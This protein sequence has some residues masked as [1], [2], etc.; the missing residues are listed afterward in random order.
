[1]HFSSLLRW[2]SQPAEDAGLLPEITRLLTANHGKKEAGA[3]Y[4]TKPFGRHLLPGDQDQL[5][6][7]AH[8]ASFT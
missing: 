2:T 1:M 5:G 4:R 6:S 3:V 8:F 7:L